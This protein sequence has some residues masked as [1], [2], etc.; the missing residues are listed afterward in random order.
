MGDGTLISRMEGERFVNVTCVSVAIGA[1]PAGDGLPEL[2]K[3]LI[4]LFNDRFTDEL[5]DTAKVCYHRAK[6]FIHWII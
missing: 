1:S 2:R 3:E 5:L 4:A 6:H